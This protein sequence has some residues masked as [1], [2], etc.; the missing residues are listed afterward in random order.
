MPSRIGP[1]L[2]FRAKRPYACSMVRFA[3]FAF[4][5]LPACAASGDPWPSLAVQ[6]GQAVSGADHCAGRVA[7]TSMPVNPVVS[8]A[9]P[10][11]E[12]EGAD[13]VRL[14]E[15][16]DA[17]QTNYHKQAVL[18]RSAM[19]EVR[20][21]AP[22]TVVAA[23]VELSRLESAFGAAA[24]IESEAYELARPFQPFR[25]PDALPAELRGLLDAL[26]RFRTDHLER[27]RAFMNE[28]G[29]SVP[30]VRPA[31]RVAARA[32]FASCTG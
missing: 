18:V 16:L 11:A 15:Q 26:A 19:A 27:Y 4:F 10:A 28:L 29:R 31:D 20:P 14:R 2:A 24:P 23:D 22:E 1:G 8:P 9:P 12:I 3:L 21:S 6:P 7:T 32:A 17:V 25:G 13:L 5:I 30:P